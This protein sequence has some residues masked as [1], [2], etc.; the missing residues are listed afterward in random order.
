MEFLPKMINQGQFAKIIDTIKLIRDYDFF[1]YQPMSLMMRIEK[2]MA[3]YQIVVVEDLLSK[4]TKEEGFM[5]IFLCEITVHQSEMFRD[6]EFWKN[7]KDDLL[8]KLN[9]LTVVKIWCPEVC[10]DEELYSMLIMLE[11]FHIINKCEIYAT[12]PHQKVLNE[13]QRGK[14]ETRK[15]ETYQANLLRV[16]DKMNISDYFRVV[17][18]YAYFESRLL[19]KVIFLRSDVQINLPPDDSFNLIMFRNRTLYFNSLLKN[20]IIKLFEQCLD[21]DG[22][23]CLG[24]KEHLNDII[25][26]NFVIYN[27]N[28]KIY[29]L[30]K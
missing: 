23:L 25:K 27:K 26:S 1:G 5:D 22:Y 19:S 13:I 18:K 11:K 21:R 20:R 17:D 6:F 10:G 29:K 8:R 2:F 7:F 4:I 15:L 30:K 28:E 12:S 14:L 24:S 16:D 3:N 9:D